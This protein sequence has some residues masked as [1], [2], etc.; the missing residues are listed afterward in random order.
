VS[1]GVQYL[2]CVCQCECDRCR[3]ALEGGGL[4]QQGK[5]LLRR[6]LQYAQAVQAAAAAVQSVQRA[7]AAAVQAV[8]TAVQ[9]RAGV[10]L[11]V[12]V[13]VGTSIRATASS[14]LTR[15]RCTKPTCTFTAHTDC[16]PPSRCRMHTASLPPPHIPV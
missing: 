16:P 12:Y 10:F 3:Q 14:P 13:P 11:C 5:E 8:Q 2:L 6:L 7:A 4:T 15:L 9:G 1:L